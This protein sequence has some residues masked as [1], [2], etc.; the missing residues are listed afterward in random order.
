MKEKS[1]YAELQK[2]ILDLML[3]NKAVYMKDAK[4]AYNTRPI[5][6]TWVR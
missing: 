6:V 1:A 3:A 5:R 4:A 2:Q